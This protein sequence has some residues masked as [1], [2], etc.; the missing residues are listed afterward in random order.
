MKY[1]DHEWLVRSQALEA[2]RAAQAAARLARAALQEQA[3]LQAQAVIAGADLE[4]QVE[5]IARGLVA[6]ADARARHIPENGN[7]GPEND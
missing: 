6:E 3:A 7:G 1:N 4:A 2:Q 5:T